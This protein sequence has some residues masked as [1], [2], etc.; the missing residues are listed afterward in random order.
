MTSDTFAYLTRI[1]ALRAQFSSLRE[2]L[3]GT[4]NHEERAAIFTDA[5]ET[6]RRIREL[7]DCRR[8]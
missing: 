4:T 8:G 2:E 3:A 7:E 1:A 6:L 5:V